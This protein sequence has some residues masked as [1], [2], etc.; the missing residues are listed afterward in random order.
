MTTGEKI[1]VE[2]KKINYTQEQLADRMY[3][4]RQTISKWETDL[5]YPETD[6]IIALA[7]LFNCT[8]D[9][10]LKDN[11]TEPT[12][13]KETEG[14]SQSGPAI[15]LSMNGY[16]NNLY[17]EYKS[18]AK[19]FG[20]P[21]VHINWGFRRTARGF[22]AIGVKSIGFISIGIIP[23]GFLS[24]GVVSIGLFSFGALA[25]A[26]FMSFGAVSM[27]AFSLGAISIGL[28]SNGAFSIGL[29]ANGAFSIGKYMAVGDRAEGLVTIGKTVSSGTYYQEISNSLAISQNAKNALAQ[30]VPD[31]WKWLMDFFLSIYR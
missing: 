3:V 8:T 31:F 20:M 14:K 4:T 19:I 17:F 25:L 28:M 22:I 2:R 6:K 10:L 11:I 7:D 21:L 18:K 24:L 27:S 15:P 16:I 23:F 5:A 13:V 30:V 1:A 26:L 9:Y 12:A 29:F